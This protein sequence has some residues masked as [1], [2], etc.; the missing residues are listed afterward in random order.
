MIEVIVNVRDAV[1]RRWSRGQAL[2]I[3]GL[4]NL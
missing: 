3:L 4:P 1:S 2:A